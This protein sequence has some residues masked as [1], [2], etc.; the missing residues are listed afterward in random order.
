MTLIQNPNLEMEWPTE[1]LFRAMA[2]YG[3]AVYESQQHEQGPSENYGMLQLLTSIK[4][5]ATV[6]K[7]L[8]NETE[9]CRSEMPENIS[10]SVW[11]PSISSD[12]ATAV[13]EWE[14]LKFEVCSLETL[15]QQMQKL[16]VSI[17]QELEVM[18]KLCM[19]HLLVMKR[20]AEQE[21]E[22]VAE[23]ERVVRLE[24]AE[25]DL[26]VGRLRQQ[27][28]LCDLQKAAPY[29]VLNCLALNNIASFSVE[30]VSPT[31]VELS[32]SCAAEGPRP[33]LRW[34]A[35]KDGID[36][37]VLVEPTTVAERAPTIPADH[38]AARFYRHMLFVDG[39][40]GLAIHPS[41]LQHVTTTDLSQT[42]LSLSL[43][44]GRLDLALAD[45]M[46]VTNKSYIGSVSVERKSSDSLLLLSISY[47]DDLH[48][49]FYYDSRMERSIA[50]SIPSRV[51]VI[52]GGIR[53][54]G[55][56]AEA[57]QKLSSTGTSPCLERI[58]DAFFFASCV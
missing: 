53:M 37:F 32:F 36:S 24:R 47:H 34:D 39:L 56:E 15:S 3:G 27:E 30:S 18:E 8:L 43:L 22:E 57:L 11:Q 20:Q 17:Q 46:K 50:H 35:N 26:A 48:V 58:C 16:D 9:Y 29:D 52:H 14:L 54:E 49:H 23:L 55:L 45:L 44:M 31:R 5:P 38:V 4:C 51:R 21:D 12:A 1:Q 33:C 2:R 42:V 41:I 6:R 7:H 19:L 28:A 13:K 25:R 40:E 10:S